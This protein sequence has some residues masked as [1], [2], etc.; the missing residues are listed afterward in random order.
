MSRSV[1]LVE[2][3]VYEK[4]TPLVS[5][6]LQAYACKDAHLRNTFRFDTITTTRQ[7]P[8]RAIA[9]D[10][11]NRGSDLYAFSC[12]LWN[13]GLVKSLVKALGETNPDARVLLGGPQV[14]HHAAELL[15]PD[16]GQVMVCNGEGEK[17]FANVLKQ[18]SD[19][20]PDFSRVRG[21]SFVRDGE[22]VTTEGETRIRDL[23]EVPSPYQTG[24]FDGDYDMGVIETNRGCPFRCG[25]C[26][27][28]AATNDKVVKFDEQRIREDITW[29]SSHDIPF[30]Y[31][32]DA[33]WG[34]LKRD[35]DI[36]RHIAQCKRE[37]GLPVF[38]YFSA[39]KNS[40]D[41]VTEITGIFGDADLLSAQ[42]ISMQT[43]SE[44]SLQLV[45]RDNIK[46]SA[47][48]DLQA[49]LNE[50]GTA[51]FIEM[52][53]PLPGETLTSFRSGLEK[54]CAS[55]ASHIVIYPH[56]LL[57]NT[58][59]YDLR[60]EHGM[61]VRCV[62][63]GAAE[64]EIVVQTRDVSEAEFEEGMWFV[65][66][67]LALYN[68]RALRCLAHYLHTSGT[69]P[70]RE[71]YSSFIRFCAADGNPLSTFCQR[72]IENIDY[73]D[74][75]N[76]PAVYHL[77]SHSER[78]AVDDLL[79]RFVRSQPWW[80]EP[81]ARV[82]FELDMLSRPFVYSNTPFEVPAIEFERVRVLDVSDRR[83]AAELR[84][85]DVGLVEKHAMFGVVE[86]DPDAG[87][88]LLDHKR[89]QRPFHARQSE[90]H[91]ANYCNGVIMRVDSIMPTVT[92]IAR[93]ATV[94]GSSL[95][96]S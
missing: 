57:H 69:M 90:Q 44:Q 35:V 21:L 37:F 39:A 95:T 6:Y 13:I 51:S 82:L 33:N 1:T 14:M 52:I 81:A 56:L 79:Y 70:Y 77:V 63:D 15:R 9:R 86:D 40:P 27:W 58:P 25:F 43:L 75:F 31:L 8:V 5:G 87:L 17:T 62:H 48:R 94:S 47:Y 60:D 55:R 45:D 66:C 18:L 4:M 89:G 20:R 23:D 61:K 65:Y 24:L 53:W 50:R 72:S 12:Y 74:I 68:T 84:A 91:N 32:A 46:L 64:A 92:R 78:R 59:L 26:F 93:A 30:L 34:M 38:T 96:A 76:Y 3:N 29:I 36:S 7:T 11:A 88:L 41:R 10:L 67:I 16:D 19:E 49:N 85:A 2:I 83:F 22:L 73:Y 28:G 42:P 71:L 80:N 54:L